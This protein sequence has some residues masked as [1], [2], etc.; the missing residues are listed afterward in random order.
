ML[1]RSKVEINV[2]ATQ[3]LDPDEARAAEALVLGRAGG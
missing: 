3:A 1:R 2:R